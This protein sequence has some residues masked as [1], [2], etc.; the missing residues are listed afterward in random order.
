MKQ[1]QSQSTLQFTRHIHAHYFISGSKQTN[2]V[3][4]K[5]NILLKSFLSVKKN[6]ITQS[7]TQFHAVIDRAETQNRDSVIPNP[8]LLVCPCVMLTPTTMTNAAVD[9]L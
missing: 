7:L 2:E 1:V 4:H 5:K 8:M 6:C 9:T 3:T